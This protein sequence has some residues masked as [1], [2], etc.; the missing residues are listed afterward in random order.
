M[1]I[2]RT[3]RATPAPD[4]SAAPGKLVAYIGRLTKAK[5]SL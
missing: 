2:E 3:T 4:F 5:E 1:A